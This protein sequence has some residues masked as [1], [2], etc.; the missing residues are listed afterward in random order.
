MIV[1]EKQKVFCKHRE[2]TD[3]HGAGSAFDNHAIHVRFVCSVDFACRHDCLLFAPFNLTVVDAWIFYALITAT[4][5]LTL[6]LNQ[7]MKSEK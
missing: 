5:D 3:L 6:H 1:L 7:F 2:V 4:T